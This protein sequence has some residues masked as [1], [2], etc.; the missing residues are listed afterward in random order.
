MTSLYIFLCPVEVR[1]L[2]RLRTK[3][4]FKPHG[5]CMKPR[6]QLLPS[7][8]LNTSLT[9]QLTK[10]MWWLIFEQVTARRECKLL[11]SRQNSKCFA[12]STRSC[13]ST[14]SPPL[15]LV[16]GVVVVCHHFIVTLRQLLM[17]EMQPKPP[18]EFIVSLQC[19]LVWQETR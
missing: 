13:L 19:W 6:E 12:P 18:E 8:F 10:N 4:R 14:S 16:G 11:V 9:S 15:L 5:I 7:L 17:T 3:I 2:R 1:R